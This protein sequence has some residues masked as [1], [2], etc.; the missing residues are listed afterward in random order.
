MSSGGA[1][2]AADLAWD[3]VVIGAGM[4]GAT[5]GHALVSLGYSV[6]F[7]ERGAAS[8][9]T[10]L[11]SELC[12][13]DEPAARVARGCW[14]EKITTVVD[15]AVSRFFAPM[16]CGAGG[17]TLLFAAALERFG[18][19]DFD[20][21]GDESGR[22]EWP[23]SYDDFLPYY[24]RAERLYRVRGTSDP[25]DADAHDRLLAPAPLGRFDACLSEAFCQ[26]GLHPYRLHV[27]L[28]QMEGCDSCPGRPCYRGCKSD[29][30]AVCIEPALRSGR[31]ELLS[32]S[33]VLR[34]DADRQRVHRVVYR[35]HG[36]EYAVRAPIIVLAAGAYLSPKLLLASAN[37]HWPKGVGNDH[38]QVGRNIMFHLMD[39]LA[40][41][42]PRKT[43]D[44][45]PAKTLGFRDLYRHE[46][47]RLGAVQS[48]GIVAN[49]GNVL[50]ALRQQLQRS[51]WSGSKLLWHLLRVPAFIA[52]R[53]LGHAAVFAT[54]VEDLPYPENRIVLD[55]VEPSGIRVEYTLHDELRS[56][57]QLMRRLL[58][59]RLVGLRSVYLNP[60]VELNYGHPCGSCR[61]GDVPQ[62]SVL[63]SS[64]RV[65]GLSN[66]YVVDASFMPSS[67]GTNP[68]LTI[69]ANALRVA[70]IIH[71]GQ[72]TDQA[73]GKA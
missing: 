10:M 9:P 40:I 24:E 72:M 56:R 58:K 67:G 43:A 71:H 11:S 68:G 59:Q 20:G 33:E 19:S 18:R 57:G 39:M 12:Q 52:S 14:P 3:V 53:L 54:I 51:R 8:F 42:P 37:E 60:E 13:A 41:W 50:F 25:L 5:L 69:A 65:H 73:S 47:V 29:A 45:M 61:F 70:D 6:L 35:R 49:Y 28:A 7:L 66:L 63:D 55:P 48:M 22:L 15:G 44:S 17:S 30:R 27:G 1:P 23:V 34:L 62:S 31:C 32:H 46:S 64:N 26:A 21:A 16:G 36:A 2:E 38:D 4:G